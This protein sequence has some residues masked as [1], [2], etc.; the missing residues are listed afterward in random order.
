MELPCH[1]NE[2]CG[3]RGIGLSEPVA[4]MDH[5]EQPELLFL[6]HLPAAKS[7]GTYA[8]EPTKELVPW[9]C[10]LLFGWRHSDPRVDVLSYDLSLRCRLS[11]VLPTCVRA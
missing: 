11:D 6:H 4:F 3:S 1:E 10:S 2:L 7:L 9:S 5:A 8:K